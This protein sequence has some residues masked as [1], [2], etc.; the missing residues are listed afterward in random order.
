MLIAR[1]NSTRACDANFLVRAALYELHPTLNEHDIS[2]H[3]LSTP[4][5]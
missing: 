2:S 5:A 1:E 4:H 3:G